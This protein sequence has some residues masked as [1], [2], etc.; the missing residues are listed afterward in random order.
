MQWP[1]VDKFSYFSPEEQSFGLHRFL[2]ILRLK[3]LRKGLGHRN[4]WPK[5]RDPEELLIIL[6]D[7]TPIR[8]R[9]GG[10]VLSL[11]KIYI[12]ECLTEALK[13]IWLDA[14]SQIEADVLAEGGK[15]LNG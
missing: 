1:G 8:Q 6:E 7:L 12:N 3:Y 10:E 14:N 2:S 15:K 13:K 11:R 9:Q 4:L 5:V